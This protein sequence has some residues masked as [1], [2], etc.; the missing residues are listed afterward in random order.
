MVDGNLPWVTTVLA[1]ATVVAAV[2]LLSVKIAHRTML[3]GRGVRSAR[4]IGAL[5]EMIARKMLPRRIPKQWA[6]DPLFHDAVIE[7]RHLLAGDEREFVDRLINEVGIVPVLQ[8]RIRWRFPRVVRLRA[9]ASLVEVA[10]PEDAPYLRRL[11]GDQNDYV[12]AH[13]A[14]GLVRLGDI[15]S[16]PLI[17]DLLCRVRPWEGARLADAMASFDRAAVK[18]I[19]EWI[20]L[21]WDDPEAAEAISQAAR[22]LGLLGEG[23]AETTLIEMMESD[24]TEWRIAA[25]SALGR[26]ASD[27]SRASLLRALLDVSWEVRARAVRALASLADSAGRPCGGGP[28]LRYPMVGPPERRRDSWGPSRRSRSTD[29][30][31]RLGRSVC[32]RRRS[33]PPRRT[34]V[35]SRRS[36]DFARGREP[37]MT[38]VLGVLSIVVLC[39]FVLIQL[40]MLAL[41]VIS[42]GALY[43]ERMLERFGRLDDM[44]VSDISP[45]VSILIPAYNEE[46]GIVESMKSIAMI[47]YPRFEIVICNDGSTDGTLQKLID[48]FKLEPVPLPYRANVACAEVRQVYHT[49]RPVSIT[50]VDKVNAGRADALNAAINVAR[51]PYV[52]LTDA[53]VLIDGSALVKAMRHVAEDRE[54]TVAVGGNVRP[55]NGCSVKFGHIVDA[56]VPESWLER[57]QLLEYV[58]SFVAAR[59]AWSAMNSLPLI[60]GAFGIY[61]RQAVVDVGGLTS[62]HMGEDMDLTMR[63]H[64]HYRSLGKPYRM[65]YA[66]SAVIWTEVPSTRAVLRRQRIRWHR[67]LMTAVHDFRS[68]FFNPRHGPIGMLGWPAMVLFEYLGADHRGRWLRRGSACSHLWRCGSRPRSASAPDRPSRRCPDLV[69]RPLPR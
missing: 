40:H 33:P 19:C 69:D 24:K 26:L 7:Y 58:R 17:L 4:Y 16:V 18:P 66:P 35:A 49:N 28:P 41:A 64:R 54:R 46:V 2:A 5:G 32:C 14:H 13:A 34:P 44:L 20:L 52:M 31:P 59:P 6:R 1:V 3:S 62:G 57:W 38:R 25:A 21:H 8:K 56:K 42:A 23:E 37:L 61:L 10:G 60:S 55:L 11:L 39:Y 65:V 47:S 12:R 43:K 68:S 27:N 63:V 45:P 29:H 53:D 48:A 51:Y 9:I 22:V 36:A 15:A 30:R 50:V 67:G